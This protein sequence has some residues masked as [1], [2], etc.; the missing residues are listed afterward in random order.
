MLKKFL[1][2]VDVHVYMKNNSL[3]EAA[4]SI[5]Q[6]INTFKEYLEFGD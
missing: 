4:E 6:F 3:A 2:A 5:L 1:I